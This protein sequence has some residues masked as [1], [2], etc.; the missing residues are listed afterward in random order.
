MKKIKDI[1]LSLVSV[2]IG[3]FTTLM[4]FFPAL[5]VKDTENVYSGIEV[6]FGH[7]FINLGGLGSGE[8]KF[9]IL[10]L[11]AYSLPLIGAITV[12]L[13]K[14]NKKI[15]TIIF[16]IAIFLLLLVP[17]FTI[18]HVTILDNINVIDVD[19]GYSLGLLVAVLLSLI[20]VGIGL[21]RLIKRN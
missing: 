12:L 20:N 2:A 19:W 14:K 8:I 17:V 9:S 5:V 10:N 3:I 18:V 21:V 1:H 15:S 6:V 7:Q 13:I 16:T 11:L 4:I